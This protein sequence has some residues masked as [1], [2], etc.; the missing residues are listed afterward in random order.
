M[1]VGNQPGNATYYR[2]WVD[3]QVG[4]VW[5]Y[6]LRCQRD[7]A[8]I[9]LVYIKELNDSKPDKPIEVD[10][11]VLEVRHHF[12]RQE[13]T[14]FIENYQRSDQPSRVHIDHDLSVLLFAGLHQRNVNVPVDMS[15]PSHESY[16]I[17]DV[18]S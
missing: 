11:L 13:N 15:L 8:I 6:L 16:P 10:S 7:Q 3:L 5:S 2:H 14:S 1:G 18:C 9:L 17:D 4:V 12:F